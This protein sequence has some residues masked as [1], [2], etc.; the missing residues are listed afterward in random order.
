MQPTPQGSGLR[1]LKISHHFF[2]K[3]KVMIFNYS[4]HLHFSQARPFILSLQT[5]PQQHSCLSS[6]KQASLQK[7][8]PQIMRSSSCRK[9]RP[10]KI[11]IFIISQKPF[12]P[13]FT[14]CSSCIYFSRPIFYSNN[15][16]SP[17]AEKSWNLVSIF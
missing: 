13:P 1:F 12:R 5:K 10:T 8:Q 17:R 15:N 16:C 6:P 2:I 4:W 9:V 7:P 14:Y 3:N 11:K